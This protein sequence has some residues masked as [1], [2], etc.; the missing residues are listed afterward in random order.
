MFR[1]EIVKVATSSLC[2]LVSVHA[3]AF[4]YLSKNPSRG[5]T[6]TSTEKPAPAAVGHAIDL[7]R[8]YLER[9]CGP[10]G[11]FVYQVD[12]G[13]GKKSTS[14]DII[15]H[16]GAIYALAMANN[17]RQDPEIV[18]TMVRSA[19]FLHKNYIG[20]GVRPG[21]LAV[22][23]KPL[24]EYSEHQY[25]ELGGT[26]LGLVAL[27]AVRQVEPSA[28]PLQDLQAL[29]RFILFLQKDDGGFVHK[30]DAISG[31]IANWQS[32]YYP[33]EAALGL[34]ALYETDH[35]R[36]W[37]EAAAKALV[38]LA[39]SHPKVEML[40]P[41]HWT[42][43]ATAKLLLD[44]QENACGATRDELVRHAVRVCNSILR[45]QFRSGTPAGIDG[46]FDPAGRTAFAATRLE[47][48]LAALE[49]IP[50][51]DLHD[52][53]DIAVSHGIAFLLRAQVATGTYAGGM[54]GAIHTSALDS[55]EVRIDN[56]QHALCA[57]LRYAQEFRGYETLN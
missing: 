47:G 8:G 19:G 31:P 13:S 22:W 49:F 5:T 41:D 54:P 11:K 34:I 53:I 16:A 1:I 36:E 52:R 57:W 56:V 33:G 10:D 46:A 23:S 30:Y 43:I 17:A 15:R 4:P 27:A 2:A 45:E 44:C 12:L 32:M 24:L 21:I 6:L 3:A 50:K 7:A 18:A 9:A 20:P 51:G 39:G 26:G 42:L 55:S 35:S 48:L 25:A 28:V 38:Y 37:L 29:G 40:P 14:Y